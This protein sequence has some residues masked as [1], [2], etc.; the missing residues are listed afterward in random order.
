MIPIYHLLL[1]LT[2]VS[3]MQI[4]FYVVDLLAF[5]FM[6]SGFY[7]IVSRPF[8]PQD[9]KTVIPCILSR[10]SWFYCLHLDLWPIRI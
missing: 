3:T 2:L 10:I 6:G 7:V 9:D 1:P 8:L 4:Y 5:S